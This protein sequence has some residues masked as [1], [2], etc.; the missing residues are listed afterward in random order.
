M[1]DVTEGV[2]CPSGNAPDCQ[3]VACS[4]GGPCDSDSDYDDE[5]ECSTETCVDPPGGTC[6]YEWTDCDDGDLCTCN[7][8]A[9]I[10]GLYRGFSRPYADVF[11][12]PCGD[13]TVEI[14]D[15]LCVLDGANSVGECLTVVGNC[16]IGDIWPCPPPEG[17]GCDGA[18]EIMDTLSVLDATSANPGCDPWCP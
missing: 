7:L 8:C 10:C 5:N 14:M 3:M 16:M 18:I 2:Q 6:S 12:V 1:L 11:P 15:T 17:S 4:P 9:N 13:N